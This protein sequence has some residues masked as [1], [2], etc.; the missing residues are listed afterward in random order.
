MATSFTVYNDDSLN[1][2][3][4]NT[5]NTSNLEIS[6]KLSASTINNNVQVIGY[7]NPTQA[8]GAAYMS[9][10][11]DQA[12]WTAATAANYSYVVVPRNC[13][14]LRA[15]VSQENGLTAGANIIAAGGPVAN[16]S[17]ITLAAARAGGAPVAG[18]A[19][20][21]NLAANLATVAVGAQPQGQMV[22]AAAEVAAATAQNPALTVTGAA[23]SPVV[24]TLATPITAGKVRFTFDFLSLA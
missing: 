16:L 10:S 4:V 14:L 17:N 13:V 9:S 8:A 12:T 21:G 1:N 11:P 23:Q 20:T 18:T 19:F 3:S 22:N 6:G 24:W 7:S 2:L 15:T 5:L